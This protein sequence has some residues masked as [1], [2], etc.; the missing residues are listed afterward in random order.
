MR[1]IEKTAEP[2]CMTIWKQERESA[3]QKL[4]YDD[5]DKKRELNDLL[6][7]EQHH[8]CCY[9]Q[10]KLTHY[11]GSKIGGSHN[12]HLDPQNGEYGHDTHQMNYYNI[13]A[14]CIDSQ[15]LKKKEKEKK[16]CGE[17]KGDDIIWGFIQNS[18]CVECFKYNVLGEIIPN[19]EYDK[20]EDYQINYS[21]L[22]VVQKDAVY[23]IQNLNLNCNYL[24]DDRK[25][26]ITALLSILVTMSKE[27]IEER[28]SIIESEPCYL[29]YI[30]LLLY[31]MKKKQ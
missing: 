14:C 17:F 24:K 20:W 18:D 27:Q 8:I 29:R 3:G 7:E 13:Y 23:T 11:Q 19:G 5:F 21:A 15:G 30:D 4:V 1:Y 16:H 28:I 2:A 6:R 26:E 31:Y 10:Q 9:C 12:E 22:P 25:K